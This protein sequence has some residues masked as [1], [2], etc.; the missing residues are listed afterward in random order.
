MPPNLEGPPPAEKAVAKLDLPDAPDFRARRSHVSPERMLLLLE[1]Y[2]HWFPASPA[3]C[4]Q[5]LK[6]KCGVEFV[7]AAED[8]INASQRR[9][10]ISDPDVGTK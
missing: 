3:G 6:R 8:T 10:G 7:L 4:E 1:E 5:R 2:R 9:V